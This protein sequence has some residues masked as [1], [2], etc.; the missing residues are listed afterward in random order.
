MSSDSE[1]EEEHVVYRNEGPSALDEWSLELVKREVKR[2]LRDERASVSR[3]K[4]FVHSSET[5]DDRLL[6][7]I[8]GI[9]KPLDYVSEVRRFLGPEFQLTCETR[10]FTDRS[11]ADGASMGGRVCIEFSALAAKRTRFW[12]SLTHGVLMLLLVCC[13]FAFGAFLLK[14]LRLWEGYERPW[15]H[16]ANYLE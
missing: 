5:V 9:E 12:R 16:F 8:E 6:L 13:I 1:Q 7:W 3:V 15:T 2:Y 10:A 4:A 11:S 14:L